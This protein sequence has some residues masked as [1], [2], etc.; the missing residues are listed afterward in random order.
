M[1]STKIKLEA[2]ETIC[3]KVTK[4][5]IRPLFLTVSAIIM[6]SF[7]I[8]S[9]H[10]YVKALINND[11]SFDSQTGF[12]VMSLSFLILAPL[13]IYQLLNIFKDDV[14][15]TNRRALVI[16]GSIGKSYAFD[17]D[18]IETVQIHHPDSQN[19]RNSTAYLTFSLEDGMNLS[20]KNL[21]IN[22][23]SLEELIHYLQDLRKHLICK[24]ITDHSANHL[25]KKTNILVPA[26][27]CLS[28][29]TGFTML[30]LYLSGINDKY[31]TQDLHMEAVI[32]NKQV[33]EVAKHKNIHDI[34]FS[35]LANHYVTTLQVSEEFY[36]SLE[37]NDI[38]AVNYK[39]GCLGI[40]YDVTLYKNKTCYYRL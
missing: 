31:E 7:F 2:D 3:C 23:N 15:F 29:V 20:T 6:L 1:F 13:S 38:L 21:I 35:N 19:G 34:M 30:S 28:I 4:P 40:I 11:L 5:K 39:K 36:N 10:L 27:Y 18:M 16:N 14:I 37:L 22:D 32:S 26:I 25:R 24:T 8:F 9:V 12:I 33:T 17:L